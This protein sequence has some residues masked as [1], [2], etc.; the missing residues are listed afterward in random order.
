M[1]LRRVLAVTLGF[2]PLLVAAFIVTAVPAQAASLREVTGFGTNP[3]NLKMYVYQ[4]STVLAKPPIVVAVHYCHGDATAFYNGSDFGRLADR[5]GFLVI[6]P[7][8][9]QA[10]DGCFDVASDATLTHNGGSDSLGIVS[11]VR[12]AVANYH[13]DPGR[14]YAVGVSSGAMMTNVLL[15][16]YPDVF[17]AGSAFAGVPFGCFA[18]NPDSLRWSDDCA[19]GRV[20]RS[21]QA[22]GDVVRAAYP[23]YTG[24]RPRMQLWHGTADETLSYVNFGEEIKE[25]TDVLGVSQTPVSTETATPQS[26]WTRTRYGGT[27]DSAAVEAVSMQGVGHNLPVQAAAAIHF[28][29]LDVPLPVSSATAVS[30]PGT[31]TATVST[32]S[33][34]GSGFVVTVT[35]TAGGS[36]VTGWKVTMALADGAVVTSVWNGQGTGSGG[37]VEV[38]N[39]SGS[40]ALAAGAST[41]FGFQASGSDDAVTATCAVR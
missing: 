30:E 1:T 24:G 5:Y 16:S 27:G 21:A 4:P 12:Y 15:G 8:V 40:L 22:W 19:K 32:A 17:K 36:A 25:W 31:C 18:V 14:V 34:W 10:S 6:Y 20:T 37:T 41:T 11:M 33:R 2:V 23:G 29:G 28:F 7:S 9:T 3:S 39:A 35:V 13:A 26:G 38:V